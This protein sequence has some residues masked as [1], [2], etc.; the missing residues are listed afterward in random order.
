M[1]LHFFYLSQN[2][3]VLLDTLLLLLLSHFSHVQLFATLWT[4]VCQSPPPVHGILQVRIL[5]EPSAN[6]TKVFSFSVTRL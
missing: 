6:K 1:V 2:T 3:I 5:E 4:V